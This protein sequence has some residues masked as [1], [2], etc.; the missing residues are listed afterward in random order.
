MTAS[1]EMY[2]E[3]AFC[4]GN[5]TAD[6][7]ASQMRNCN[8]CGGTGR[9]HVRMTASKEGMHTPLPWESSESNEMLTFVVSPGTGT[10]VA[11]CDRLNG[12]GLTESKANSE[13]IAKACNSYS[14]TREALRGILEALKVALG[15]VCKAHGFPGLVEDQIKS[16]IRKA[17]EALK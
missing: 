8:I 4:H 13:F 6:G 15:A 2:E 11:D 5:G 14:T 10:I 17:E 7:G 3:C 9:S 1:K 12:Q 16:A